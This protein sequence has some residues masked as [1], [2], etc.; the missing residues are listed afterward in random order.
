MCVEEG[1]A[2]VVADLVAEVDLRHTAG[3]EVD[4]DM[5][6]RVPLREVVGA[7]FVEMLHFT[8]LTKNGLDRLAFIG[9]KVIYKEFL[10]SFLVVITLRFYFHLMR[11]CEVGIKRTSNKLSF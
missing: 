4:S 11:S 9:N 5:A 6:L 1:R 10:I 2:L 8:H 7:I 3:N